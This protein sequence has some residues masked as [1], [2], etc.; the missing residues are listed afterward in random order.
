MLRAVLL[1]GLCVATVLVAGCIEEPQDCNDPVS[2]HANRDGSVTVNWDAMPGSFGYQV[3]RQADGEPNNPGYGIVVAPETTF[4]DSNT[5]V[6]VAYTY[7]V[8]GVG[9]E[10]VT[11][12]GKATV[13]AIPLFPTPLAGA[14]ALLGG[15]GAFVVL[16]RRAG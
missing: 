16:R 1:A 11:G 2:A 12:C 15:V 4:H 5:T 6:G 13:T 7:T 9:A 10:E 8:I 14:L 3:G